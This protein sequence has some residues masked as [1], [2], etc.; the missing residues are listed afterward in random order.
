MFSRARRSLPALR[1]PKALG[2]SLLGKAM[3]R[4]AAESAVRLAE[5]VVGEDITR[6]MREVRY[7][8]NEVGVDPFGFDPEAGRYA[9]ALAAMLHRLYFRTEVSGV[10]K[11]PKGRVLIIANHSGQ[12][13][14]DGLM[15]GTSMMLDA[16]P[17]RFPR[18]MVEKWTAQL[19]FVS[20]TL[21]K[22][23]QVVGSPANARRLL[24]NEAALVV[25]PE[26][27]R[28]I[29]KPFK[30]RYQLQRFGLGFMRLAMET[31]TPIVPV[32][33]IGAEEQY[34]S[35]ADLQPIARMLGMPAFPLVP[36]FLIGGL[37]PLPT[38]YRITFSDPLHFEGDPDDDDAVIDRHVQTVKAR[39]EEMITVG[40]EQREHVFY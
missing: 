19:P 36:Q 24:E 13:P 1:R 15:I 10:E 37:M 38:K 16:N 23:G 18:S 33:V 5:E 12:L 4:A 8:R 32:S 6:R 11:I 9:L 39:I 2:W 25:F 27:A 30:D 28:G 35:V 34:P 40:L 17:P 22:L 3:G 21:P 14:I 29:S 31:G 7:H 20:A 26:G